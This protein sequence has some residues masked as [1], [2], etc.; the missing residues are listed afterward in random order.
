MV[1]GDR[2]LAR[3]SFTDTQ[4]LLNQGAGF[5]IFG[6][7]DLGCRF[8]PSYCGQKGVDKFLIVLSRISFNGNKLR[9]PGSV[10]TGSLL[11]TP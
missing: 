6:G 3:N 1:A 8:E 5:V 11:R 7:G 10:V 4:T 2:I 9:R